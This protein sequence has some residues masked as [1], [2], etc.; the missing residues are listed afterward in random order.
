MT[1]ASEY[2]HASV[3]QRNFALFALLRRVEHLIILAI[4]FYF[5]GAISSLLFVN[6]D[7]LG[8]ESSAGR[9]TWYPIYV[10]I[11]AS[12]FLIL[13]K[14]IRITAYNPMLVLCVLWCGISA[15][16]SIEMGISLRRGV[17]LL[18]TTIFGLFLAVKYD[19]NGLVQ[20][21]AFIF[22]VLVVL[23]FIIVLI[24]PQRGIMQE[25]HIGAWRG[26]WIEKNYLGSQMTRGLVIMLCAFAMRP[27]RGW[28][29]LPMAGLCFALVILSTSKT[30]LLASIFAIALFIFIRFYRRYP[31]LR[32]ILIYLLIAGA[33]TALA[34][35][36]TIPDALLG[37]IGKDSTFTGR[38]DIWDALIHSVRNRPIL[39]YGYAAYWFGELGPSYYVRL[40]L[41]WGVPSAHN[42]WI[43]T[44]L[45]V[46]IIGVA[47]FAIQYIW[48]VILAFMRLKRGGTEVYW[49]III[50]LTF[51]VF[52]LSES[53]VLQQ[54]DLSWVIFV[55]TSAKL[56][57]FENPFWRNRPTVNYFKQDI[58]SM[59][60]R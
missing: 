33:V 60:R 53:S 12:S 57:S 25:P 42:G 50:T 17:A 49:A 39:G 6:L 55:A 19:W 26:P 29:W 40:S 5:T 9:I 10:L 41:Q 47:L 3:R 46:G 22:A 35:A 56:F 45:S 34:F 54:N 59:I 36:A 24:D 51:L 11:L 30:A 2:S 8:I 28:L 13:P 37:L 18:M 23:S 15:I 38:T 20:R 52:S 31:I 48:T 4:L 43:E 32:M 16:W 1:M 27:D 44:W 21:L 14:M 7:D 58:P